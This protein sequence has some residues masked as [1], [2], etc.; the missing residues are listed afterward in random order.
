MEGTKRSLILAGGGMRV[1][2]Q[3]GVLR[4]LAEEGITF[5]HADGTSGGTIN[6]AMM[7]S[8]LSPIE[9][10]QRWETLPVRDFVSF[11]PL[12][13]YLSHQGVAALGDARSL[14]DRVFPHLGI[15]M[16]RIR[17]AHGTDG[18]FN[19]CNFT[20]K[21]SEVIP[22]QR[23]TTDYLVAAIS[24]P[25]FLPAVE[26]DGSLYMDSVWIRDANLM[27]A[28]RRGA[29]ELWVV[30]CIGNTGLYHNG[31]F[32][33]YVHMIEIAANGK[34]FEEFDQINEINLRIGAGETVYGRRKPIRVHLI[35]PA[36]ALPLDPDY[37]MGRIDA[38]TLAGR[39]YADAKQY[40]A[41]R[42]EGIALTPE[43]TKMA[44]ETLGFTFREQ[45]AGGFTLG[46]TDPEKGARA[47]R[48]AGNTFTM[49]ATIE[50]HDLNRFLADAGHLGSITGRID[51]PPLGLNIP[52]TSGVFNLFSPTG[53]PAMKYMVYELGF[54]A[55]GRKYYM[56]GRKE[57]KQASITELWKATTT[58]YTQLHEGSD[59]TGPVVGAGVLTLGMGELMAMI[60]TMH[61][62]NA[63]SP[64][65]AAA[66]VARFGKFFLGE[67]WDTYVKKAGA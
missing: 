20:R 63:K 59:K 2:Y 18:T 31:A 15:D 33:Q 29:D 66:A 6:L 44:D 24:L 62:T 22:H 5:Q 47:G 56:A 23:M 65:E 19:V 53:D 9:M 64:E 43:A 28:V 21:I 50:I 25:I 37:Y 30:W 46:E 40:L 12:E 57:V 41:R 8:G 1:A 54:E 52:T 27:E 32:R 58:L 4:A 55:G 16:A 49:H 39:G 36:N 60:P 48:D 38:R 67:L 7:L 17:A 14:V 26:I 3:A 51:F 42:G 11:M 13:K 34:L 10:M 61:A 45:M 35:K